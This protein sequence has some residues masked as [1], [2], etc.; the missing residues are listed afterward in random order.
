MFEL[1]KVEAGVTV[2]HEK[3]VGFKSVG[4]TGVLAVRLFKLS[5]ILGRPKLLGEDEAELELDAPA[6]LDDDV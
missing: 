1:G 4:K 6:D 2:S 3:E 5:F